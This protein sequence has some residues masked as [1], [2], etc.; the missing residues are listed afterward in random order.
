MKPGEFFRYQTGIQR[1]SGRVDLGFGRQ[2]TIK[3]IKRIQEGPNKFKSV[4]CSVPPQMKGQ[5]L[6]SFS[7]ED[8]S[9]EDLKC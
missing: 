3:G 4:S 9:I 8:Q 2:N 7:F 6:E 5:D 1:A